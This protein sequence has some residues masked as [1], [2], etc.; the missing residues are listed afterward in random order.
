MLRRER[1]P[2]HRQVGAAQVAQAVQASVFGDA[3]AVQLLGVRLVGL[4]AGM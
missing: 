2:Q 3:Q 1:V 4:Q